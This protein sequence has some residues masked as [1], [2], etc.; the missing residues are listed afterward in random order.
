MSGPLA[1]SHEASLAELEA[2]RTTDAL[3]PEQY[4]L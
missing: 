4:S 2:R 1:L 3:P